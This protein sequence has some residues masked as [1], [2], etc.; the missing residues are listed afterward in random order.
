MLTQILQPHPPGLSIKLSDALAS[1]PEGLPKHEAMDQSLADQE[2]WLGDLQAALGAEGRRALLV[3]L[4]GRDASGKDGVVRKVFGGVN[5]AL[6][7][8]TS[9]KKPSPLELKHDYLWRVHQAIP[10]R[11]TI[12]IF[13]RSHYEDVVAVR[14]H[15]LVAES[16]WR[17]RFE[18]INAF[19]AMLSDEGVVIRKFFL[20]ISKDE[21]RERLQE[22]LD[23]PTKNWKFQPED[24]DE[25]R[26]WDEYTAAYEEV[27]ERC[28]TAQAPWYVVPG[29]KNKPRDYLIAEVLIRTLELM[30]P[31]YPAANPG[32][33]RLKIK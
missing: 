19:E 6:C 3:V 26:L 1:P 14:V 29:D 20:H 24:L 17:K 10:A 16:V 22:R 25:R 27:L 8:V 15:R 18:Q 28:S 33:L 21:Q 12:G 23:D 2:R 13:N 5:P 9:F 32:V 4:Q 30:N 7:S 11:G 31:Q